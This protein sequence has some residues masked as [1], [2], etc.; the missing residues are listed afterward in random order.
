LGLFA[1]SVGGHSR[2]NS[3]TMSAHIPDIPADPRAS[4]LGGLNPANGPVR[5]FGRL[6][7]LRLLGKSDQT[8]A[9]LVDDPRSQQELLLLLPRVQPAGPRALAL[10]QQSMRRAGRVNHPQLAPVLESGVQDGW[11]FATYE[12]AGASTLA[13]RVPEG[14][15][16]GPEA[17]AWFSQTLT[18]LAFA[19]EAGVT[20]QDLQPFMLWIGDSGQVRIAGL[21]VAVGASPSSATTAS[22]S[23]AADTSDL[24]AHRD[25]AERDVL[26]AGILLH[27]ALCGQ[28]ALGEP[29]VGRVINRLPPYCGGAGRDIV[30]LPWAGTQL[31]ADPLRA[32][33]NRATDRQLRQRYRSARTF[34]GALEGWQ[35]TEEGEGGPLALLADRMRA[36]GVLPS[37]PGAA[38]RA[39]R[40]ATMERE[41]T[42]DLAE[43]VLQD[44]ALSFDLLRLVNSAHV[45]GAQVSGSGP[46]LTVR[47]AIA[48]LG[49]DGVRHA[50]TALREWPGPMNEDSAAAL[51]RLVERCK[52]AGRVAL[53]LR[54]AGFDAE[55]MYL[56]CL[57]QNLGRLLVHYHFPEEALQVQRLTQPGASN[58]EGEPEATGMTEETAAFAV[59][60]ADIEAIGSAVARYW[61]MDDAVL[62]MVR[63][64]PTSTAVHMSNHDDDQLRTVA[65]C[66]NEAVDALTLP[67]PRVAAALQ[68]V[69]QRY[70]RCLGFGT[71]DLQAALQTSTTSSYA[72]LTGTG[73]VF[74]GLAAAQSAAAA[75]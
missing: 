47:R 6:Q 25:A 5:R 15:T 66:A 18:G 68:R 60:G 29:D 36:A 27:M 17:A 20:H 61:G 24:Q 52:R 9:W 58:V 34:L 38:A 64:L 21:G 70:G 46:V 11:P 14:G 2:S 55:V 41:R 49:M 56:I 72:D 48:M 28:A 10:W 13:D 75:A 42:N 7:L 43:V 62:M 71:R 31:L 73:S 54:P 35:R 74:G 19:H 45:R 30:R 67:A 37:F 26:A 63:R 40:L 50:A 22:S 65:S 59:L 33:V 12:L 39:A 8:M 69:V 23:N 44:L 4:H 53:V 57:L 1:A 51:L 32:I 3:S 16:L